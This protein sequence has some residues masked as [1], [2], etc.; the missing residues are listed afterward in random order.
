MVT[1]QCGMPFQ[2][3]VKQADGHQP[4]ASC[5]GDL[6]AERGC[7]YELSYIVASDLAFSGKGRFYRDYGSTR[8]VIFHELKCEAPQHFNWRC[9]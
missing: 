5:F 8:E 1:S 7:G 9:L 2:P 3:F 4:G 6:P